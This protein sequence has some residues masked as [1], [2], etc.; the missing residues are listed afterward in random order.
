[1]P[2][3]LSSTSA[4]SP[5]A[6]HPTS[7]QAARRA[8]ADVA[9]LV[10]FRVGTVR[11]RRALRI[12]VGILVGIT[13][14]VCTVPM[15]LPD[16]RSNDVLI[17]MPTAFA[18]FL[19][20]NIV[21]GVASGGGRELLSREQGVAYPVS[22]TTDHLGALLMAPLNIAWLLQA[23]TIL[24][25]AAYALP[26]S[27]V[28]AALITC[29]LWFVVSTSAAQVVAWTMEA[30]RRRAHGRWVVRALV[31]AC[32]AG[33]A[34]LQ[35]TDQLIDFLDRLPTLWLVARS[36][37]G[38][39]ASWLTG[40]GFE[41][42]V[43][44]ATVVLGAVPAHLAAKLPSRDEA[45]V[46]GG[47]YPVRRMP[48]TVVGMLASID[49]ASVWRSVP[50]RRGITVLAVGP[51]IVAILGN[52]SWTNMTILPGLVASGGALLFGVNAWC[53]D[54]RGLLWRENLPALPGQVFAARA[55]VLA[56]FVLAASLVTLVMASLR[57]GV[58][59][60]SELA[61]MLM[62]VLVVTLQVLAAALRWSAQRPFPV[63]MRSARATPAPPVV[64]VGYSARLALSTTFTGLL[65]STLSRFPD[66]RLSLLFAVPLLA[67]SGFR[68]A[69]TARR[70]Q[71]PVE[72]SRVVMAV[73]S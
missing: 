27:A 10:R 37:D 40:V 36:L 47:A 19:L 33:A 60:A 6:L 46:E 68:F 48:R 13:V 31:G 16:T 55:L 59:S 44:A 38:F 69:R 3:G 43:I 26:A 71:D 21:S 34:Y 5:A 8:V 12:A 54:G 18:A 1:M 35:L 20:L 49:R 72:R 62:L 14:A 30:I 73:A 32:A 41:L 39:T 70:W 4:A 17:V 51:G 24:G 57:A 23:W 58:P 66:W 15:A 65:F 28:P 25:S 42:V 50:M 63:D 53:L 61:A 52:M 22:P 11:R 45:K 29:L 2:T 56:E 7:I 9:H 64:M 67:W